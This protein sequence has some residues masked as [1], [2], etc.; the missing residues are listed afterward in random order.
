MEKRMIFYDT[1][2]LHLSPTDVFYPYPFSL[3]DNQAGAMV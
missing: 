2:G 3:R 1:M